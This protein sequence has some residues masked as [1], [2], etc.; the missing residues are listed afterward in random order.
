ML[1]DDILNII[2]TED[3]EEEII[4]NDKFNENVSET[5]KVMET[6]SIVQ[7]TKSTTKRKA[8]NIADTE[9]EPAVH[10]TRSAH[11]TS[12]THKVG[13]GLISHGKAMSK[14]PKLVITRFSGE[15]TKYRSFWASFDS[16]IHRNNTLSAIDKFNYLHG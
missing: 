7:V 14:L 5:Q 8:T 3:I 6:H 13:S 10:Q 16:A 1:D 11:E 12:Q 9:Q 2:P 15:V 4:Q